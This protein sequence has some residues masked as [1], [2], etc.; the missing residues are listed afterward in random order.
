MFT[1]MK[2]NSAKVNKI[3]S[4]SDFQIFKTHVGGMGV[5]TITASTFTSAIAGNFGKY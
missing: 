5:A 1:L 3:T 2:D 4:F